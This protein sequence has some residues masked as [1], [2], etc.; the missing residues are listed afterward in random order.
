MIGNGLLDI[1]LNQESLLYFLYYHGLFGADL[2][3]Q[4]QRYCCEKNGK[5][6]FSNFYNEDCLLKVRLE[7]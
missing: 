7:Q 5:C 1:A 2:W 3:N 4:L 6:S